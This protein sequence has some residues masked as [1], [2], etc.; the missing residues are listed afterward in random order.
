[1]RRKLLLVATGMVALALAGIAVAG[2]GIG[3]KSVKVVAGTFDATAQRVF[4]RSCT[5]TDGKVVAVSH[6]L[7][8]GAAAGDPDLTGP[9]TIK[10][11][12]LINTTDDVGVVTGRLWIATAGRRTVAGFRAVYDHGKLVGLAQ[13]RARTPRA[14]L[15]ANISADFTPAAGFAGGKIGNAAG[16]S[17]VEIGPGKCARPKPEKSEA[18]GTVTEL[19]PT[20]ITVAGLT[21]ALVGDLATKAN[22]ALDV[23]DRAHIRCRV[24]EGVNTLVWF[25]KKL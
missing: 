22:A 7:Y 25:K 4:T 1:M 24:I 13:G 3:P 12:S 15:L 5:T 23:G 6:G 8:K 18:R 19:T 20:S 16:G 10:A 2:H 14:G 17:A 9:I 11:R 21:C